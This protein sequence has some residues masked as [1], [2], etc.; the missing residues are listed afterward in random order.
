LTG[1]V[2]SEARA[3]HLVDQLLALALA[4]EAMP[5]QTVQLDELV[6]ETV[7]RFWPRA[8]AAGVDLG[9][10][11]LEK[12][13]TVQGQPALIEGILNN[14][15]DNAMRYGC[16]ESNPKPQIT[17]ALLREGDTLVLSVVDN[18][19]GIPLPQQN[20]LLQRGTQGA[21]GERLGQG[22]GLGLSIVARYAQ[23]LG[24]HLEMGAGPQ[25]RGLDVR[26]VF[27]APSHAAP[28]D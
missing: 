11:G 5:H 22:A 2:H 28:P 9:A 26:L 25:N 24:A 23:L 15:I 6:R 4:D 27:P 19:P 8:D 16:T 21:D 20:R 17:V 13:V 14:L 18:G 7:L 1:I 3:S 10:R 12:S